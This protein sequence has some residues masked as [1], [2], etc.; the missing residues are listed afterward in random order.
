MKPKYTK[1][2]RKP[3]TKKVLRGRKGGRRAYLKKMLWRVQKRIAREHPGIGVQHLNAREFRWWYRDYAYR[4][5]E[6][7][8]TGNLTAKFIIGEAIDL[9]RDEIVKAEDER[10]FAVLDQIAGGLR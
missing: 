3:N 9:A 6:E 4:V 2:P 8:R 1:R 7:R 10:V 5:Q